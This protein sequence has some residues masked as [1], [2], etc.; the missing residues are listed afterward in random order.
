MVDSLKSLVWNRAERRPRAPVRLV[1]G[2]LLVAVVTFGLA[3][4][5]GLLGVGSLLVGLL[6]A[7]AGDLA[8]G[9]VGSL[10]LGVAIVVAVTVAGRFLDRRPFTDFGFH[11]DRSWWL[12]LGFGLGLGAGLMT[13][14]F[15]V[16][17]AAGWF[18]VTG[19][20]VGDAV[21]VGLATLVV[22]FVLVGVYEELFARGYLL[23][24]V[25]EGLAG[26]VGERW[27]VA[28]AVALSSGVFGLL[29]ASNPSASLV[30]T[31]TITLAGVMLALGYVLTN[32]L[33]V[34][35]GLHVTW[36]LFQGGVYGFPVSGL[37]VDATIV[38]TREQGPDL[39][40][41]G[42]FGPEAGLLGVGA[43]LLGS[44]AIVAWVRW[45]YGEVG[46]HPGVTTP[47]LRTGGR[48][49]DDDA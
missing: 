6:G 14:V 35:V 46:V 17:V 45:R 20:L 38:A 11:L 43:M 2:L 7:T 36:N 47:E 41:G 16:G 22:L 40:T 49:G 30:S 15:G 4:V 39:V 29:H 31:V 1:A 26:Y 25:A 3:V 13:L 21:V 28:V 48:R 33:A 19:F 32:E 42:S 10:V 44:A 5:V 8:T 27:A 24:N 18:R 9:L 23:T 34:P 12:D 37:G